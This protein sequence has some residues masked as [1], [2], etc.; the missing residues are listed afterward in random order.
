MAVEETHAYDHISLEELDWCGVFALALVRV[1]RHL[2]VKAINKVWGVAKDLF[3]GETA[4]SELQPNPTVLK[5]TRHASQLVITH[6]A[7]MS[8]QRLAHFFRN[9]VQSRNWM[10]V[11]E[12]QEPRKV[13]EMV[14]REAAVGGLGAFGGVVGPV[15]ITN[16]C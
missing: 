16:G 1:G 7:T 10:T 11:R 9:S 13:V 5:A 8:G 14:L 2:E 12:A 3:E 4:S 15:V 6:Y